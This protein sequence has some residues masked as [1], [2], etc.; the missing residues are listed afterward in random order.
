[1]QDYYAPYALA[2]YENCEYYVQ[3]LGNFKAKADLNANI[4]DSKIKISN[5]THPIGIILQKPF[6][7][8]NECIFYDES[9]QSLNNSN[10]LST[11]ISKNYILCQCDH[12]TDFSISSLNPLN[13]LKDLSLLLKLILNLYILVL[14]Y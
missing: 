5:L 14:L 3:S 13:L 12:L 6:A 9:S 11:Q 10:C 7:S 8:F 1:M 2:T 4:S